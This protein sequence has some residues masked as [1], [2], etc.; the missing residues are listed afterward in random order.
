MTRTLCEMCGAATPADS[1]CRDLFGEVLSR[2]YSDAAYGRVHLLT[3]DAYALQHPEEH[4][5][6]SNAFHLLRL[7]AQLE[8]G[9][10]SGLGSGPDRRRSKQLERLYRQLPHL[11]APRCRGADRIDSVVVA[12]NPAEHAARVRGWAHSVWQAWHANH[13]WARAEA[14]RWSAERAAG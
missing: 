11:D 8:L 9:A 14:E 6:R 2:E 1:A 7:C 4:G 5:P 13:T 10:P 12:R 3:V